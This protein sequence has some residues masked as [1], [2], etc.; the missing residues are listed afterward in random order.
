MNGY[1]LVF[2]SMIIADDAPSK[3]GG[4]HSPWDNVT[5]ADHVMV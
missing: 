5:F 1:S 4:G 2:T 3:F